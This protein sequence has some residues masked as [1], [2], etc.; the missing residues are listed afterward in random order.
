MKSFPTT[1]TVDAAGHSLESAPEGPPAP[2]R[3]GGL[4][5]NSECE[6]GAGPAADVDAMAVS[7]GEAAKEVIFGRLRRVETSF[8]VAG[9]ALRDI[10]TCFMTCAMLSRRFQK[11]SCIF[12]GRRS[13]LEVSIVIFRGRRS[14][15]DVSC[16]VFL[17]I[18]LSGLRQVVKTC[19]IA[20]AILR[21]SV[22]S[23]TEHLA[24]GTALFPM[25][26]SWKQNFKAHRVAANAGYIGEHFI[27]H[28]EMESFPPPMRTTL[29]VT[30]KPPSKMSNVSKFFSAAYQQSV[31]AQRKQ[32]RGGLL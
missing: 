28:R 14:T 32:C 3:S 30:K 13:T 31:Q 2:M 18:A 20:A 17:R 9:V 12:R 25:S 24:D 16:C 11:L 5:G 29:R 7:M 21:H 15:L 8:R 6:S 23:A 26:S 10:P 27:Y 22:V 4:S 1:P 19:K